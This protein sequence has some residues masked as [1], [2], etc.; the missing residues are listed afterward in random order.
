MSRPMCGASRRDSCS[1]L[2]GCMLLH[3]VC[4]PCSTGQLL[5]PPG[6]SC[7][8]AQSGADPTESPPDGPPTASEPVTWHGA[9]AGEHAASNVAMEAGPGGPKGGTARRGVAPGSFLDLLMRATNRT[10]GRGFTDT[11]IANQ[12]RARARPVR[13][14]RTM[15]SAHTSSRWCALI[16]IAICA[17]PSNFDCAKQG[18]RLPSV[19]PFELRACAGMQVFVMI[20]AGYETTA[21]ALAFSVYLLSTN[22]AKRDRLLAEL[23]AFGRNRTPTLRD[24]DRRARHR[25]SESLGLFSS[26]LR[27]LTCAP[28]AA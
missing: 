26:S 22:P 24:L 5:L 3:A 19:G 14:K 10:T 1:A 6:S 15:H 8:G 27:A 18:Y 9:P 23:D 7:V 12:A 13:L 20:L 28:I 17:L 21:N 25:V 11:E 16:D 4:L 2:N